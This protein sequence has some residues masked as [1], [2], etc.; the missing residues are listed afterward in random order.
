MHHCVLTLAPQ[1]SPPSK[2]QPILLLLLLSSQYPSPTQAVVHPPVDSVPI[3]HM[4]VIV[5]DVGVLE[6]VGVAVGTLSSMQRQG[7]Q[8]FTI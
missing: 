1:Q 2:L 4:P 3:V 7:M 8:N 6:L 5:H